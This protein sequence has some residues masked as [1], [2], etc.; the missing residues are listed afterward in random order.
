MS[1]RVAVALF[2]LASVAACAHSPEPRLYVLATQDGTVA[3]QARGIVQIDRPHIAGYLDRREIVR[4]VAQ[5]LDL[6][7]DAAWAEPLDAMIGRVLAQDLAQRAPAARIYGETSGLS[8]RPD[9]H[10]GL[11]VQRFEREPNGDVALVAL[12]LV[13][14]TDEAHPLVL[15]Q[16]ALKSTPSERDTSG[17]VHAL[18][19]L[20]GSLAD[21]VARMIAAAP[22]AAAAP[23]APPP[24]P[25]P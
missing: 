17:V 11:D 23:P 25:R 2:A 19:G 22:E 20:L 8:V 15:E 5:H 4:V 6:A 18:S 16:V 24:V 21:R 14:R 3:N 1:A 12:V 7:A 10:V 9:L 13:R